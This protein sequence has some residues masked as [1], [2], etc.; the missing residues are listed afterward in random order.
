[1]VLTTNGIVNAKKATTTPTMPQITNCLACATLVAS[2]WAV[3]NMKAAKINIITKNATAIGQ[4]IP[5]TVSIRVFTSSPKIG[6]GIGPGLNANITAGNANK[7]VEVSDISN[8][9][10]IFPI[11]LVRLTFNF[12]LWV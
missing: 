4:I 5:S 8:F 7:A 6:S 11:L 3:K 1:M 12:D 2:P 9:L 10:F